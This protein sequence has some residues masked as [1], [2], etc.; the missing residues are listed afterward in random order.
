MAISTSIECDI[1]EREVSPEDEEY[2]VTCQRCTAE[3]LK[4]QR[5]SGKLLAKVYQLLSN[6]LPADKLLLRHI[7]DELETQELLP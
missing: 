5:S 7:R 3:G 6:G 1:C 4:D 2:R